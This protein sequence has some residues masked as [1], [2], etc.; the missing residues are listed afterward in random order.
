MND[1]VS[2]TY[3]T[4]SV[5]NYGDSTY[6]DTDLI[7][8]TPLFG[9]GSGISDILGYLDL[10]LTIPSFQL[11]HRQAFRLPVRSSAIIYSELKHEQGT[12]VYPPTRRKFNAQWS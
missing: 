12:A 2:P 11:L 10:K 4:V 6:T 1:Q 9:N 3:L 7:T 5:G 8:T